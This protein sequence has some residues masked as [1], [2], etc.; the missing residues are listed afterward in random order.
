M[1]SRDNCPNWR[2]V[3]L[4]SHDVG[5]RTNPEL[6]HLQFNGLQYVTPTEVMVAKML[7]AQGIPFTPNVPILLGILHVPGQRLPEQPILYVPDFIFDK[8]TLLWTWP[9]GRTETTQVIECKGLTRKASHKHSNLHKVRLLDRERH[10][11]LIV[12]SEEETIEL[13]AAGGLP[14]VR[15]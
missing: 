8:K 3:R 12:L 9:D 13:E 14:L 5:G 15:L 4:V 11:H 7:T 1:P 6:A 2:R 10:I